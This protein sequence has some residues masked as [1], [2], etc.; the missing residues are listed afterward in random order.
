MPVGQIIWGWSHCVQDTAPTLIAFEAMKSDPVAV[1]S[2][3]FDGICE[4]ARRTDIL[5]Y[6]AMAKL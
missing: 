5:V 1:E 4:S 6:R 3:D 2:E